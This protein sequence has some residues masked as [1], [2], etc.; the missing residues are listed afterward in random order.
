VNSIWLVIAAACTYLVGYRFYAVFIA[1]R[2]MALDD[3]RAT[4]LTVCGTAT[5]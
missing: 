1:A 4:P 3:R 2:A 5:I